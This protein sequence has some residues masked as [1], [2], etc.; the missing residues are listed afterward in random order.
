M[1]T[2]QAAEIREV[3]SKVQ[4]WTA[5]MRLSLAEQLLRSLHSDVRPN[6]ARTYS[7]QEVRGIGAGTSPPPDDATVRQWIDEHR[8]QKYG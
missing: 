8:L 7:A 5:E 3:L 4:D 6:P 2:T 1:S